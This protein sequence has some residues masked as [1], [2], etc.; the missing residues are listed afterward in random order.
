MLGFPLQ[1]L[2]KYLNI[3]V[4]AGYQVKV[5]EQNAIGKI[6]GK[7]NPKNNGKIERTTKG[8]Y[9]RGTMIDLDNKDNNYILSLWLDKD[10]HNLDIIGVTICDIGTGLLEI[11]DTLCN[12]DDVYQALDEVS[13]YINTYNPTEIILSN[14]ENI[15]WTNEKLKYLEID[16]NYYIFDS[17]D[18]LFH[19][20]SYQKHVLSKIFNQ[21]NP[22][23]YLDIESHHYGRISLMLLL[24]YIE[25][26][27]PELLKNLTNLRILTF[28]NPF[29]QSVNNL[30]NFIT[31]LTFGTN[32][33]QSVDNL[34]N[35][36]THLTFG[37]NFNQSVNNL[38][39]SI[40]N[41]TLGYY[42]NQSVN[43]LSSNLKIIKISRYNPKIK[44]ISKSIYNINPSIKIIEY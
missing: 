14:T 23:E 8:V 15:K 30:P 19:K 37:W 24:N 13:L 18:K 43:N 3:L 17:K 2:N 5:I 41:L 7:V 21:K 36:I 10:D 4:E 44:A 39:N 38:P 1:S 27:N 9:S 32:F 35:S 40:T 28:G 42:F 12:K 11:K 31:N 34:P 22:I 26:H 20:L 6:H 29:D 33:N 25:M 16:R